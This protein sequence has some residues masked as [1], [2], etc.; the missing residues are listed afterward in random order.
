MD[1]R[2]DIAEAIE[3]LKADIERLENREES[4]WNKASRKPCA[5]VLADAQQIM[6]DAKILMQRIKSYKL[7]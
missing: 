7:S 3:R 2:K 1:L 4:Y 6:S 5:E